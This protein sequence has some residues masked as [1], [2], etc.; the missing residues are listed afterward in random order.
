IWFDKDSVASW[1]NQQSSGRRG[2]V[3]TYSDQAIECALTIRSL[4]S[5]TLRQ[6]QGFLEGMRTTMDLNIDIPNYTTL[7]RRAAKLKVDLGNIKW[8]RPVNILIDATGLKVY[9]EGEWKMRTHGK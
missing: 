5:L 4:F 7:S 3:Q 6:T 1:A 2:R 8:D 9:G